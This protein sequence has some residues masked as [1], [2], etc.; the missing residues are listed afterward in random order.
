MQAHSF[1]RPVSLSFLLLQ[2]GLA[3]PQADA[4]PARPVHMLVQSAPGGSADFTARIVGQKL[5]DAVKQP[6]LVENRA[7]GS[8]VIATDAVAKSRP[9]GYTL[10]LTAMTTH[11]TGVHFIKNPPYDAVKD[12]APVVHVNTVPMILVVNRDVPATSVKDLITLA[13]SRPGELNF[14]TLSPGSAAHLAAELFK[15]T[16]KT[17]IVSVPYKG[18]GQGVPAL[19]SGQVQVMLNGAP[20]LLPHIRSGKLRP[21]AAAHGERNPLL[22]DVPTFA[23]LGFK[24]LEVGL[25]YGLLVPAKSPAVAIDRLNLEVNRILAMAEVRERFLSQGAQVAGGTPEQFAAFMRD[26]QAKWGRL[27]RETGIQFE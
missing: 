20:A 21:L 1:A 10:L 9:D 12:F 15:Y 3:W 24:N 18:G 23:E 8:G 13:K 2:S 22:P 19:V 17:D 14:A 16:T 27:I 7:G 5:S 11:G 4:Y 25:W 6:V 26:E